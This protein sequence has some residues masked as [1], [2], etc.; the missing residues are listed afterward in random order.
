MKSGIFVTLLIMLS[1]N[2]QVAQ[3]ISFDCGKASSQVEKLICGNEDLSKLD[4]S[5]SR[6]YNSRKKNNPSLINEQKQWL[7][8]DR[9]TCQTSACLKKAYS[10]R[11][12]ALHAL[13]NCQVTEMRYLVVG[14]NIRKGDI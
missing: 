14:R 7:R 8:E 1:C 4:S 12:K 3:A 2:F 11:I 6:L 5:L 9:N 13:D 10:R